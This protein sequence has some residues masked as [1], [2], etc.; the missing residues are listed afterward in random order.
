[1]T[2][3]AFLDPVFQSQATFRA[4][5]AA[6]SRPGKSVRCG[7]GLTPPAP[8]RAAAGAALLSLIDFETPL[9]LSPAFANSEVGAWLRFHTDAPLVGAPDSAAFALIDLETDALDLSPYAR[10]TAE[11]PDRSTTIVAQVAAVSEDG[12]LRLSGPGV[13]GEQRLGFAPFPHDFQT[14]WRDNGR[15]F[16]LGVDLILATGDHVVGLPRATRILGAA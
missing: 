16:P 5:L 12:P 9:W 3:P 11:Y 2:A 4:V 13:R 15:G 14:Q 8:L 10:G 7:A 6:M 1:M